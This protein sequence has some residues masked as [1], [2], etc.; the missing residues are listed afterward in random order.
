MRI[1]IL[2]AGL[3]GPAA[4]Y[5]A[6]RDPAVERVTLAD[7]DRGQLEAAAEHLRRLP[8]LDRLEVEQ[9][10]LADRAAASQLMSAHDAILAALPWRASMLAFAAALQARVPIVDL[11]IPDDDQMQ[12]LR[13][14]VGDATILLGCG[15]EPGLTEIV[16]RELAS[17]L[18]SVREVHIKVGGIPQD[19]KPPLGY[20]IVYG[21]HELPLRSIPAPIIE[22]GARRDVAR[23]SGVETVEFDGVGR[24]EAWHEGVLLWML[25]HPEFDGVQHVTQKTVRWPG[26]AERAAVL[27]ELGLLSTDPVDVG[28]TPVVPKD[29]VDA[30]LHPHVKLDDDETDITVFRVEVS[31]VRNGDAAAYRTEMIDRR[32]RHTGFTSMARTTAFTGAIAAR[33]IAGGAI[34]ERGLL[35]AEQVFTG[36]RYERL[37]RELADE[38]IHFTTSEE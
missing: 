13:R 28:G 27:N 17:R 23:Y 29:L 15:L 5:N 34:T 16:A 31:G 10:D 18:D 26:Y 14:S 8:G 20:K 35:T 1:L 24:C 4:A 9:L 33:M 38:G 22:D 19:P 25:D 7:V 3:M 36:E 32:D 2:G 6:M 12:E 21:G 11:A 37:I 30:V